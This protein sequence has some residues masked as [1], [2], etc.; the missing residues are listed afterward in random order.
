MELIKIPP[1]DIKAEESLL[2]CLISFKNSIYE[3]VGR[4]KPEHFYSL[5]NGVIYK[6]I[7]D[8]QTAN[9]GI[10]LVTVTNQLKKNKTLDDIG[11]PVR[12]A[13]LSS[14]VSS[15]RNLKTYI[16]I[17]IDTYN[18]RELIPILS[19]KLEE[20]YDGGEIKQII[21]DLEGKIY[22]LSTSSVKKEPKH[23]S[24]GLGAAVKQIEKFTDHQLTGI[25][26]PFTRLNTLTGGWQNG[27]LIIIA[28]RPSH[29]KT[30]FAI[31]SV[32]ASAEYKAP[33]LFFS[34]EMSDKAISTRLICHE[35]GISNDRIRRGLQEEDWI[36]IEHAVGKI[37]RLPIILDDTPRINVVELV[38]KAKRAKIKYDIK[39]IGID[40]LG[41]ITLDEKGHMSR[42]EKIGLITATMKGMAMELDVPVLL[43]C[44][45]NRS[46][47]LHGDKRPTL[48]NLRESG[49]IEQDADL[50]VFITDPVKLRDPSA[51]T[52]T[53]E[54]DLAKHRNG[55][56]DSFLVRRTEE[57]TRLLD[58]T[59]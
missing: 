20:C 48:S 19:D 55:K 29:G 5:D 41:F 33:T 22:K 50:V 6:A 32:F 43:L 52:N 13:H 17:I 38:S 24:E 30:Q 53:L 27:D 10:D 45:L 40:Y 37:E 12:V 8:L 35:T 11:G 28:G 21:Q 18:T 31:E 47:E 9:K 1:S 39:L 57:W 25:P 15:D 36:S 54:I 59:Y 4:L 49:N 44:Q 2:S 3:A 26:T 46:M 51:L 34:L 58:Y 23:I 14:L 42:D 7:L 56:T 16:D